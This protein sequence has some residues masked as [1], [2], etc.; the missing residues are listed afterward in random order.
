MSKTLVLDE[1]F[2][3]FVQPASSMSDTSPSRVLP[4]AFT[5]TG[6]MRIT[7]RMRSKYQIKWGFFYNNRGDF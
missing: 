7:C 1:L 3:N 5:T 6:N 4:V 2:G